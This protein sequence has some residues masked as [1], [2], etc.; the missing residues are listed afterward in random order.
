MLYFGMTCSIDIRER[1]VD[2]VLSGGSKAEA[3]RRYNVSRKSVYN[4]LLRGDLSPKK[5][6]LRRRKLDKEELRRHVR[7]HPDMLLR[8]R[9][10]IFGISV[11]GLSIALKTMKIV[12]KN[13]DDIWNETI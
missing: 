9:A 6:G 8:E 13:N 4:W 5:H 10:E 7:Q 2:F 11:P 12:K 3:A 1:V